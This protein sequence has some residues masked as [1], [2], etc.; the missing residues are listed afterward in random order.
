MS[1][2]PNN[3]KAALVRSAAR[4]PPEPC[5]SGSHEPV[6]P[7]LEGL[8]SLTKQVVPCVARQFAMKAVLIWQGN[9]KLYLGLCT[10]V[11]GYQGEDQEGRSGGVAGVV[12]AS[13]K[14]PQLT[15]GWE[16]PWV[17]DYRDTRGL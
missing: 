9:L 1:S 17:G 12:E 7:I 14:A 13:A 15:K 2:L 3:R 5:L 4:R 16:G 8:G 11:I 6:G 10:H